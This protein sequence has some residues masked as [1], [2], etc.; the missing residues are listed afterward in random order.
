MNRPSFERELASEIRF[1]N[2]GRVE[3]LTYIGSGTTCLVYKIEGKDIIIK[4]FAPLIDGKPVMSRKNGANDKLTPI[5][6]LTPF[7]LAIV[8]ERKKNF[9]SEKDII[10]EVK[11]RYKIKKG[12]MFITP[13]LLRGTTLYPCLSCQFYEGET[14]DSFFAKSKKEN[15]KF[16]QHFLNILP[17]IIKLYEEIA[18]YHGD[19]DKDSSTGGILNLDVKPANLFLPNADHE[20]DHFCIRNLDFGSARRL[21]DNK[22]SGNQGLISLI[23]SYA[24]KNKN[25]NQELLIDQIGSKFFASSPGFYDKERIGMTIQRCINCEDTDVE[26]TKAIVSD[27]KLL[28]ILA[29]WKTFLFAL[30]DST[31]LFMDTYSSQTETEVEKVYR[32]FGEIFENHPL[33]NPIHNSLFESYNIYSQLYE[34]MARSFKGQR[35]YRLS[36][37]EIANRLKNVLCILRGITWTEEQRD[38]EAMNCIFTQKDELLEERGLKT[39]KDIHTFCT[40]NGL[41][42]PEKLG[43]LHWFLLFG[44]K[45]T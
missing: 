26:S 16:Q 6:G 22:E 5:E 20:N 14:L 21:D 38:L 44:E 4:E 9:E 37:S 19:R 39:I 23:C 35:K 36:A 3:R 7:D 1:V 12:N 18:T 33:T 45:H 8:K 13:K 31:D 24:A 28:D 11:R 32:V 40:M 29:A 34:I 42:W 10:D 15:T 2:T 41:K 27:F 43:A 17:Y 25:V 30:S